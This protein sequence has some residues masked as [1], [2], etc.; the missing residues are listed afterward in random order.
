MTPAP[1]QRQNPGIYRRRRLIAA[2][3]AA[4][5]LTLGGRGAHR[6]RAGAG[7]EPASAAGAQ[8]SPSERSVAA[9]PGD[10]LWTIASTAYR[11]DAGPGDVSFMTYLEEV[12]ALNGGTDLQPGDDVLLP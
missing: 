8:R 5:S 7:G 9:N 12:I 2:L 4:S 1:S 3:V 6:A 11:T 10:S